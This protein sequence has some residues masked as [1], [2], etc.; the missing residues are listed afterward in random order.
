MRKIAVLL[1][2]VSVALPASAAPRRDDT[3]TF[4]ERIA[5]VVRHVVQA[6]DD[7]WPGPPKP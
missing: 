6:L 7:F 1:F 4:G 3:N 5:R 2:L